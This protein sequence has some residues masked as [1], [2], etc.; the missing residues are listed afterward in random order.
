M[1]S[2]SVTE[3]H[4]DAGRRALS[5]GDH[6]GAEREFLE[7]I[8]QADA[9]GGDVEHLAAALAAYGHMLYQSKRFGE[10][11][12]PLRRALATREAALGHDDVTLAPPL[13]NLAAVHLAAGDAA[14]AE[15]LLRRTLEVLERA[16]G[17][18]HPEVAPVL[19]GLS[20]LYL[21]QG[22]WAHAEPLLVRLLAMRRAEGEDRPEVA[23]VM[24]SLATVYHALA[25]HDAAEKLLRRVLEIRERT[26]APNH[27]A[28][29]TTLEALAETCAT[30]GKLDEAVALLERALEMRERTLGSEHRSLAVVRAKIA[31]LQLQNSQDAFAVSLLEMAAPRRLSAPAAP[32]SSAGGGTV[33]TRPSWPAPELDGPSDGRADDRAAERAAERVEDGSLAIWTLPSGGSL[34][35]PGASQAPLARFGDDDDF[36]GNLD[37]DDLAGYHAPASLQSRLRGHK[38]VTTGAIAVVAIA[39]VV[40]VR[41]A[42]GNDAPVGDASA[43]TVENPVL[44]TSVLATLPTSSANDHLARGDSTSGSAVNGGSRSALA[45]NGLVEQRGPVADQ[46]STNDQRRAAATSPPQPA[47]SPT[48]PAPASTALPLLD[49]RVNPSVPL[50]DLSAPVTASDPALFGAGSP[51]VTSTRAPYSLDR[52]L[53]LPALIGE[54]PEPRYPSA[55]RRD[56]ITGEVIVAFVVDTIGRVKRESFRV[57]RASDPRFVGAVSAIMGQLHFVPA[58]SEGR[59]IAHEVEMAFRFAP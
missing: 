8:V 40:L 10:A 31:D 18:D 27:F 49:L 57:V 32:A 45:A 39:A 17:P 21:K 41:A 2:P 12:A 42:G 20:Q 7:A 46:R 34:A 28:I 9:P 5:L 1:S 19:N 36:D 11:V 33:T 29:A 16:H 4:L 35:L 51:R 23:T 50:M 22:A 25:E 26:L 44:Q 53:R 58:E 14:A 13:Y 15:P 54:V 56:R 55:L 52:A 47:P 37:D 48:P 3:R 24:A 30:R 43:A 59:K 38:L 6:E